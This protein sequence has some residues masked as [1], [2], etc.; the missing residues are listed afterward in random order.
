MQSYKKSVCSCYV[1]TSQTTQTQVQKVAPPDPDALV[2]YL[3]AG[4]IFDASVDKVNFD[5]VQ[6]PCAYLRRVIRDSGLFK[7]VFAF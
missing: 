1:V 4:D 6:A 7:V 5:Y 2:I 3:R